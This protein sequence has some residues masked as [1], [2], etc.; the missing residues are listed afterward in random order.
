MKTVTSILFGIAVACL[1]GYG[2][3]AW[4]QAAGDPTPEDGPGLSSG[5]DADLVKDRIRGF[6]TRKSW[7]R[8]KA[9]SPE[10]QVAAMGPGINIVGGYEAYW[11]GKKGTFSDEDMKRVADAG[12]KTVR[13]PLFAFRKIYTTQGNL[14]PVWLERL[15]HIIDLAIK[16]DMTVILDEHDFEDCAKD[17]DACA[18]LLANVWYELAERY[19]DA[20]NTVVFEL[21]NEPNGQVDAAIWNAWIPDLVGIIRETNPTRNIIVGPVMWNSADQLEN[22]KLPEND[23]N[24]IVT[25]HYY[26]PMEFTHQ[27]ASWTP[28]FQNLKDVRWTGSPEQLAAINTTFDKVSAWSK[29]HKRPILLGEY[30][31]YG[32]VNT[33][34]SDRASW[35]RAVTQA[36]T[37]R[38]FARAYW[39]YEDGGGFGVWDDEKGWVG[40][41]KDALLGN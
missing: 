27:G 22:L 19:K 31:A 16:N 38:G 7:P 5:R 40:P 6:E 20:P 35:T 29:A 36:A 34:L 26:T 25:F 33:N 12:F 4:S 13:I 32:K 18:I 30:G 17:A 41:I 10:A 24:L 3:A 28:D 15:D 23:R 2:T 11:E 21:L 9:I 37:S 39:Y 8:F 1:S 14:D